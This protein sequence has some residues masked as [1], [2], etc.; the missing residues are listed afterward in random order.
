MKTDITRFGKR[1]FKGALE[2]ARIGTMRYFLGNFYDN[3]K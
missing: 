2:D 3:R 1:T